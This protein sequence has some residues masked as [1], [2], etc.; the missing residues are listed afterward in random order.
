MLNQKICT[1]KKDF[2]LDTTQNTSIKSETFSCSKLDS[3]RNTEDN[4]NCLTYTKYFT[5][6]R[7]NIK[8]SKIENY[9]NDNEINALIDQT[10]NEEDDIIRYISDKKLLVSN[11]K[12]NLMNILIIFL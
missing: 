5:K 7:E 11:Y 4:K 8:K 9:T 10:N 6:T 2:N 1:I 12:K 3:G